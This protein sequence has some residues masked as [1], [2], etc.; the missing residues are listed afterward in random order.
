MPT[1]AALL[2]AVVPLSAKNL[3]GGY[4]P[5]P[6]CARAD[7][8]Y[9]SCP[10]SWHSM[11]SNLF[12]HI[13]TLRA[14][15]FFFTDCQRP[16]QNCTLSQ[17]T[18]NSWPQRS[19]VWYGHPRWTWWHSPWPRVSGVRLTEITQPSSL[20]PSPHSNRPLTP[21]VPTLQPSPHS[22]RLLTTTV[23]TLQPSPHSN[24]PHTP[25][26]PSLQPPSH[27]TFQT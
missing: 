4:P 12:N 11:R 6:V 17:H 27:C 22:N 25:T 15:C 13:M 2:A 9:L 3:G 5:P 21:T 14:S 16:C 8:R 20:Q 23:P 7:W 19:A 26:V 10:H 1:F 24:R 18:R